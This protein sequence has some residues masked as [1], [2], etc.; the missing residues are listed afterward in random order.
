MSE[1]KKLFIKKVECPM[2]I[3]QYIEIVKKLLS[4][5]SMLF[6]RIIRKIIKLFIRLNY[7]YRCFKCHVQINTIGNNVLCEIPIKNNKKKCILKVIKCVKKIAEENKI[8]D[9]ILSNEL[10]QIE[11]L[12][13]AFSNKKLIEGKYLLKVMIDEVISYISSIKNDRIENQTIYILVSEY[14]KINLEIIELL[15]YKAKSVNIITN[16]LNKFLK[17]ER[18]LYENKGIMITVSNNKRKAL[19]KANWIINLDFTNDMIKQYKVNRTAIFINLIEESTEVSRSFS[20]IIVNGLIIKEGSNKDLQFLK[21][22]KSFNETILYE[23]SISR[24]KNMIDIKKQIEE[25]NIKIKALIGNRGEIEEV[26][27]K[28][29]LT[30]T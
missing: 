16:K 19:S 8:K 29:C 24:S 6:K 13:I 23:S 9:I 18:N 25:D 22:C 30:N 1:E 14:S 3:F 2:E 15:S 27:Y 20:G 28:N 5:K 17:F 12:Q 21:L 10:N 4:V 11:E 26:E 7:E